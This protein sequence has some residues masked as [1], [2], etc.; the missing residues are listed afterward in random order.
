MVAGFDILVDGVHRTFHDRK[1]VAIR[2]A[3]NLKEKDQS[4]VVEIRCN[5]TGE[6]SIILPDGR[7]G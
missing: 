4:S 5:Q 3:I 6:R 2:M 7:L 1:E